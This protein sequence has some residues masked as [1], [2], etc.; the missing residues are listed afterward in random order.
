VGENY[1]SKKRRLIPKKQRRKEILEAAAQ[2]FS[3]KGYYKATVSD[4]A[5]RAGIGH[6]TVYGFFPS[7]QALAT[8]VIGAKGATGFLEA[9]K[10]SSVENLDAE[11]FLRTIGKKYFGNLKDRLPIIR[12]AIAEGV[13]N[14][15][16]ARQ[17]YEKLLLRLFNHLAEH[18]AAFQEKGL[19]KKADPFLLGHIF[20]SILFG[21]L[22]SQELMFGRE[23]TKI[24][25]DKVIDLAVD[26]FLHGV[27]IEKKG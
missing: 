5:S 27:E 19:F 11:E 26:V 20:Y 16:L 10:D 7:K 14:S 24:D 23:I 9:V 15:E 2:I 13:S 6:G 3:E 4:I 18:M 1:Q 25:L 8:E 21:F 22:Y 17:Y 12:F